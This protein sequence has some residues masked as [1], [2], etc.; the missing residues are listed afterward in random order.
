M[1]VIG[2]GGPPGSGK[3][4]VARELAMRP[5]VAW[6]DL[7]RVAWHSYRPGTP[8]FDQLVSRYGRS[9]LGEDGSIDR[10]RLARAAFADAKGR[11]DLEALVH[12]AV[13]AALAQGVEEHRDAGARILL[14][15]GALLGVSSAVDYTGID[16]VLWLDAPPELRARR[17]AAAGRPLHAERWS[18]RAFVTPVRHIRTDGSLEEAVAAVLAAVEDIEPRPSDVNC[19]PGSRSP[20]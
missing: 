16:V 17:L 1:K 7:D 13:S 14:V 6:I 11:R 3:S 5:S 20:R 18:T 8:T 9:I 12:P 15:E 10:Q 2:L 4:A 19:G